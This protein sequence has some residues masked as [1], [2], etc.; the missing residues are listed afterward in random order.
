[1]TKGSQT[2]HD[3]SSGKSFW[4]LVGAGRYIGTAPR[5]TEDGELIKLQGVGHRREVGGPVK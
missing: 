1:M 4:N 3:G 2:G 5:D